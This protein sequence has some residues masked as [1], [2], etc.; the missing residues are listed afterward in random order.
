MAS[1]NDRVPSLYQPKPIDSQKVTGIKRNLL[2][3]MGLRH[4]ELSWQGAELLDL[5]CR[6]RSQIFACDEYFRT[7]PLV[8]HEGKVPSVARFY[9]NAI[10]VS[11]SAL[12]ALRAVVAE[13]AR[14]D[15]RLDD[16][17]TALAKEG[18]KARGAKALVE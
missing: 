16:A 4:D 15:D 14:Q 11:I 7:H 18:Q 2:K 17:L 6:S 12:E 13:M 1:R 10:K 8:E 3:R 5:Y 9:L